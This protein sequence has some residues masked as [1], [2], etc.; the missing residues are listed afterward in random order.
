MIFDSHAHYD[1]KAFD[2]D[3]EE[4]LHSLPENGIGCVINVTSED[5]YV[6]FVSANPKFRAVL[7]DNTKVSPSKVPLNDVLNFFTDTIE[8]GGVRQLVL[9]YEI[10]EDTS[11][12]K[13]DLNLSAFGK[14]AIKINI[15]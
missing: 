7:N 9:I 15:K 6:D 14:D 12:D 8:G 13:I 10:P 1:D 4:L 11:I 3:R 5:V 2:P